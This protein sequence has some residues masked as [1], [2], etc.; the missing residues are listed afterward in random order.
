MNEE[1]VSKKTL[2]D[3]FDFLILKYNFYLQA[4]ITNV[5]HFVSCSCSDDDYSE[6]I[7]ELEQ[8]FRYLGPTYLDH[9]NFLECKME[10]IIPKAT[11]DKSNWRDSYLDYPSMNKD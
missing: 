7:S 9:W 6:I 10:D 1:S 3:F 2:I 5:D 11:S 8:Q 4:I